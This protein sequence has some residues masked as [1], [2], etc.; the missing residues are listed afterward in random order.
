[1]SILTKKGSTS[2]HQN[3]FFSNFAKNPLHLEVVS[4]ARLK[5][6]A[7]NLVQQKKVRTFAAIY[8]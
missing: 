4:A 3:N 6:R 8:L 5:N 1:M 2:N 7:K